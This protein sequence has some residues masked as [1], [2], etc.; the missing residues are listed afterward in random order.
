MSSNTAA[1]HDTASELSYSGDLSA[2]L[3]SV[4]SAYEAAKQ[5]ETEAESEAYRKVAVPDVRGE[6]VFATLHQLWGDLQRSV[7]RSRMIVEDGGTLS[8][9]TV[10]NLQ[11]EKSDFLILCKHITG[12]YGR[13]EMRSE[14]V[15]STV[16][17]SGA[18]Q[19]RVDAMYREIEE[20]IAETAA[21]LQAIKARVF[22]V[23]SVDGDANEDDS[24]VRL[25]ELR[26]RIKTLKGRVAKSKGVV[27]DVAVLRQAIEQYGVVLRKIA[28]RATAIEEETQQRRQSITTGTT[29]MPVSPAPSSARRETDRSNTEGPTQP[30]A[31]EAL[32]L[33]RTVT[34]HPFYTQAEQKTAEE[35]YQAVRICAAEGNSPSVCGEQL[36]V[37]REYVSSLA[38]APQVGELSGRVAH[39]MRRVTAGLSFDS[40][41]LRTARMLERK[42]REVFADTTK[43]NREKHEA[44]RMLEEY[45]ESHEAEWLMICGVTIP[46]PG[47]AGIQ[48]ARIMREALLVERDRN[49]VFIQNPQK[50]VL[51]DKLIRKL[52]FIPPAGFGEKSDLVEIKN[53]VRAID[54]AGQQIDHHRPLADDTV[55]TELGTLPPQHHELRVSGEDDA[56]DLAI[57]VALRASKRS[58]KERKQQALSKLA[59]SSEAQ[60]LEGPSSSPEATVSARLEKQDPV[61]QAVPSLTPKVFPPAPEE[62]KRSLTRLYLQDQFYQEFILSHY[63]SVSAFDRMLDTIITQIESK[64]TDVFERWLGEAKASPFSFIEELTVTEVLQLA[65]HPQARQILSEQN[66]KYET[67]LSWIDLIDEMQAVVGEELSVTFGQLYARWVIESEMIFAS[68]TSDN[69]SQV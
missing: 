57:R 54:V 56:A 13:S 8:S 33:L 58:R 2:F 40:D 18:Q 62:E 41:T 1:K 36:A 10:R 48:Q 26:Q 24:I 64:T 9:L 45:V 19:D 69:N 67:F 35:L 68:E 20:M 47:E 12:A 49:Q 11:R 44:Y 32:Q 61:N 6:E 22:N 5:F 14:K 16:T 55:F 38:V 60:L 31:A 66:I 4:R 51:V 28:N 34:Y 21:H 25:T 42:C 15:A 29:S 30:A 53:L 65:G 46:A 17:E 7:R 59:R 23:L 3:A 63:A 52:S 50:Q 37:L 43:S 27:R 39:I